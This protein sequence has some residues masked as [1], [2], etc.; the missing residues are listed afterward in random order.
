MDDSDPYQ[1]LVTKVTEWI[2]KGKAYDGLQYVQTFIARKKKQFGPS[3][4]SLLIFHSA[5]L[6]MT[7][8][9]CS[10]AGALIL[11]FIKGGTG[12]GY[13]FTILD[14]SDDSKYCDLNRLN[15][16]L[17]S[18]PIEYVATGIVKSVHKPLTKM[19][20]TK[21]SH[22]NI[23]V[24]QKVREFERV[25]ARAFEVMSEWAPA[26]KSLLAVG[27]LDRVAEDLDLWAKT[28]YLTEY[29]MFFSRMLLVLCAN[30]P[31]LALQL[32]HLVVK[33]F[34]RLSTIA[35]AE[36]PEISQ[37]PYL[38]IWHLAVMVV[39]LSSQLRVSLT[40]KATV[41]TF[42]YNKYAPVLAGLD[43]KLLVLLEAIGSRSCGWKKPQHSGGPNLMSMLGGLLGG[44]GGGGGAPGGLDI[45]QMMRMLS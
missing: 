2:D 18:F 17:I 16:L 7:E 33:K 1:H 35:T 15:D 44:G 42:L 4:T 8:E 3:V 32:L 31:P 43:D 20:K 27:D 19:I 34:P 26:V 30:D 23:I 14:V 38:P 45:Q 6:F 11:W 13:S 12:E 10:N 25:S 9:L 22:P 5:K 41:F 39:E 40:S 24:L 21:F 36:S 29:P 28:G 37:S